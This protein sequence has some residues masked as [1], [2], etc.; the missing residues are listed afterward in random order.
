MD[1]REIDILVAEKRYDHVNT[2]APD[3]VWVGNKQEGT[4]V[5]S[6]LGVYNPTRNMIQ[7]LKL[8]IDAEISIDWDSKMAFKGDKSEKFSDKSDLPYAICSVYLQVK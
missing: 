1:N 3:A 7:A 6:V 8:V 4:N 5:V 2:E